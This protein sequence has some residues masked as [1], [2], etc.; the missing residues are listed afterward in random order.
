MN[1]M[2]K[3]RMKGIKGKSTSLHYSVRCR[4]L[5]PTPSLDSSGS[6]C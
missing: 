3:D 4:F 2:L 1:V 6:G 5:A